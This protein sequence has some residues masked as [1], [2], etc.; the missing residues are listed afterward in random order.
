MNKMNQINQSHQPCSAILV[1]RYSIVL[2]FAG[3]SLR[4]LSSIDHNGQGL[5]MQGFSH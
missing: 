4:I 5:T 3:G 2:A 1:E